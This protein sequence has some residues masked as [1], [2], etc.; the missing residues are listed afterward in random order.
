MGEN[1]MKI[2]A[3]ALWS[4]F[5]D[6][7]LIPYLS[8]SV[9]YYRAAVTQAPSGGLIGIQRP[10]DNEIF[11]PYAWSASTLQAGDVC[12]VLMFGD[13]S[14][15]IVI[16][17]GTLSEP[18]IYVT[19]DG[20][21]GTTGSATD[22]TMTQKAI[23]DALDGKAPTNHASSATTYGTGTS[24]NYGHLKL[25]ASTSSTS[26]TSGG[27]AATPSAVKAAYD[28][29]ATAGKRYSQTFTASGW[30]GSGPYTITVSASTHGCGTDP[31]VDV[32]VKNGTAYE[33]YYG[34]PSGGWSVSVGSD[35]TITLSSSTAF[36]GKIR[37]SS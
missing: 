32:L 14:N 28:L 36:A 23:T 9:C 8:D 7:Y 1:E 19:K 20:L 22:N 21:L 27:I 3:D 26:G 34:Y 30:A 15:A 6:K 11:L 17:D 5:L 29:A 35:G 31:A 37:V 25:S 33:K 13:H 10:F 12:T 2:M 24:S 18:G 16:G 4:Y